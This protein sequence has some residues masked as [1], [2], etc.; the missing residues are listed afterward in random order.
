MVKALSSA[1][2]R[3]LRLA[4]V[5]FLISCWSAGTPLQAM[6]VKDAIQTA[7]N[8]ARALPDEYRQSYPIP[9]KDGRHP[10]LVFLYCN[11]VLKPGT[12]QYLY[13]PSHRAVV[14]AGGKFEKLE[15]IS[16]QRLGV[17]HEADKALGVHTAPKGLAPEQALKKQE[18]LYQLYDRLLPAFATG[19]TGVKEEAAE[20]R[21]LFVLLAEKP[22]E[23]YYRAV[24]KE[25]F[26][27][28]DLAAAG[29]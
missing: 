28:L 25:F 20:F 10:Q 4:A 2:L 5:F 21:E 18:R 29:K 9:V 15:A 12:G 26:H 6:N 3:L 16:P 19:E 14:D 7:R 23:P 24:G 1:R 13:P 27:W 11:A 22:L 8:H 17:A